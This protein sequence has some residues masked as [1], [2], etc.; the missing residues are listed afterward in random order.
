MKLSLR[1]AA[2]LAQCAKLIRIPN[3]DPVTTPPLCTAVPTDDPPVDDPPI[4]DPTDENPPI[5]DDSFQ[6]YRIYKIKENQTQGNETNVPLVIKESLP[7]GSLQDLTDGFDIRVFDSADNPLPYEIIDL[8]VDRDGA[9][10]FVLWINMP[11]VLDG[12]YVQVV[13]GKASATDGSNRTAVYDANYT[14]VHHLNGV[15]DDSTVNAEDFTLNSVT[16]ILAKIGTGLDFAGGTSSFAIKNPYDSFPTTEITS[17]L[18]IQTTG[19]TDV[20]LSYAVGSGSELAYHFNIFRQN[21]LQIIIQGVGGVDDDSIN[22]GIFHHLVVTW[23]SSDGKLLVYDNTVEIVNTNV[24]SGSPFTNNG[25]L[26]LGQRQSSPG[27]ID[28][29]IYSFY[30]I[31]EELKIS[32]IVRSVDYIKST[33]NNQNDNDAFWDKSE[34]LEG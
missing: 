6:F 16:P 25:S 33:F 15:G 29:S 21:S 1:S 14:S 24:A 30:G 31:L 4:D 2:I 9:A 5:A 27:V 34:I 3:L 28:S 23:R 17:E 10:T 19:S 22:D 12:E 13:F 20:M 11:R 7:V 8:V 32:D 18:W 26:I